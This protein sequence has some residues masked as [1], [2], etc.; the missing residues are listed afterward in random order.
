VIFSRDGLEWHHKSSW[1]ASFV[2][3]QLSF[4]HCQLWLFARSSSEPVL[5]WQSSS[6]VV[7]VLSVWPLTDVHSFQQSVWSGPSWMQCPT[8]L[9]AGPSTVHCIHTEDAAEM[10]DKHDRGY[11]VCWWQTTL[12]AC[13]AGSRSGHWSV[14]TSWRP[15]SLNFGRGVLLAHLAVSSLTPLKPN[16]YGLALGLHFRSYQ[17]INHWW[18]IQLSY[19]LLVLFVSSVFCQTGS[20]R[21]TL[22]NSSAHASTT[23]DGPDSWSVM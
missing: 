17:P 1:S 22:T 6:W 19:T 10:F 3:P 4:W 9:R 12:C 20:W 23:S 13:L 2:R 15:A 16:W 7:P 21:C 8:R 11:H 5:G 14:Y 18:S